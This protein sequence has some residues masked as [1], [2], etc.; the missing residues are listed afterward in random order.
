VAGTAVTDA[1][2]SALDLPHLANIRR[3]DEEARARDPRAWY[4]E[5][6]F[7]W[8]VSGNP[9]IEELP[10]ESA[11]DLLE[12][13]Y[14]YSGDGWSRYASD[15][16][17]VKNNAERQRLLHARLKSL[18]A[19]YLMI[20]ALRAPDP[21]ERLSKQNAAPRYEC[22]ARY[23]LKRTPRLDALFNA[24]SFEHKF[25]RTYKGIGYGSTCSWPRQTAEPP[26]DDVSRA[27]GLTEFIEHKQLVGMFSLYY[28][29]D[30]L[31]VFCWAGRVYYVEHMKPYFVT[32]RERTKATANSTP[33][34]TP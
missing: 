19:E 23:K 1:G 30:N 31:H 12:T 3:Y 18:S 13:L 27:L 10:T 4:T 8:W 22:M 17:A 14:P 7:G 33:P 6:N 29:T 11:C 34:D 21:I 24:A 28:P 9:P 26:D 15:P 2:V 25:S 16:M 20:E 5:E 32:E